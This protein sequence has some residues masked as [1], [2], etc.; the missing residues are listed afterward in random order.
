MPA[1]NLTGGARVVSIYAQLLT[2]KGHQ[3]TVVSPGEKQPTFKEKLKSAIKWKGYSFKTNFNTTFFDKRDYELQIL[4]EHRPIQNDD[5]PDADIV[6]AT[7]WNTA[8]WMTD[9]SEKKGKKV[10][11]IQH[12]ETHPWL[13]MGRVEATL[14]APFYQITVAQWIADILESKYQKKDVVV[15]G[16]GVDLEQFSAPVREKNKSL[17]VGVMYADELS[18]KGCD[19]S[20]SSVLK[21]REAVPDIKLVAF[22]MRPPVDSL[23]MPNNSEFYLKPEQENIKTIY[24]QCDAWLF[25]S[26]SEGFGLPLLEAMACRTPVI[27]TKTGAAPELVASAD[28]YLI[29]IDDVNAMTKAILDINNMTSLEWTKLSE[30]AYNVAKAHAWNIK[31]IEFESVLNRINNG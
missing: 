4:D 2:E 19:T 22:A 31:V 9:F 21:A 13:P 25:G 11:F 1:L 16:N 17:T 6:I 24:G 28:G 14:K 18:F 8:E 5:I 20:I 15:V 26:R 29:D 12:Y 10:Y 27:A 3:V 23:P 7:F 30:K